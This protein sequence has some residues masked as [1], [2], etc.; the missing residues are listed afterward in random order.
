[1]RLRRVSFAIFRWRS[2]VRFK[3]ALIILVRCY[4]SNNNLICDLFI[5]YWFYVYQFT[6]T[7]LLHKGHKDS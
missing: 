4:F 6:H 5:C 7:D 1:M 2:R 3:L